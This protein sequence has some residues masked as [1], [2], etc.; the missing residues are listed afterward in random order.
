MFMVHRIFDRKKTNNNNF[1]GSYIFWSTFIVDEGIEDPN[2]AVK[3]VFRWR[4][5]DSP[6]LTD[7]F[8]I[9]QGIRTCVAKK[10]YNILNKKVKEIVFEGAMTKDLKHLKTFEFHNS[11]M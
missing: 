2:T 8:V 10:S 4:A 9:F 5:D 7:S 6:T 11:I 1:S 3:M